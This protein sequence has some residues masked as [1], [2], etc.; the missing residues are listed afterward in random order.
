MVLQNLMFIYWDLGSVPYNRI[1]SVNN[2]HNN[3]NTKV[4]KTYKTLHYKNRGERGRQLDNYYFIELL[5]KFAL[6]L[7]STL[8]I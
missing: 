4:C 6:R 2:T 1:R 5:V 7:Q 8:V 3:L